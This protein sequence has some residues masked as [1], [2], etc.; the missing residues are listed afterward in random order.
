MQP[1]NS[2]VLNVVFAAAIIGGRGRGKITWVRC[3][4]LGGYV[5]FESSDKP[6]E[7]VLLLLHNNGQDNAVIRP[8][9]GEFSQESKEYGLSGTKSQR[10]K[11]VI[12]WRNYIALRMK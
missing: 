6:H 7:A 5:S 3:N 2:M 12:T 9:G 10:N 11:L 1:S 8:H 4:R